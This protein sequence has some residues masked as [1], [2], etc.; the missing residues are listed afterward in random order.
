MVGNRLIANTPDIT[1]KR[2]EIAEWY[3]NAF[4]D[5]K[6]F[7]DIPSRQPG[8]RHVYHLYILRV[9]RRDALLSYL[10]QAGVQAKVHYPIPVHLQNASRY[11]GYRQGDFPTA[12]THSRQ[13]ITL[14][15]HQHL[16]DD[17]IDYVIEKVHQFYL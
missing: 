8:I 2:I 14:P 12:E 9:Q 7:I 11:L 13:A 4:S 1:R 5:L 3:D 10:N 15:C 17:E 6:A 16:C